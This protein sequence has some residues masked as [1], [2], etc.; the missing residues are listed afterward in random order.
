M[1]NRINWVAV[2][3]TVI[4]LEGLGFVWYA[5]L[6]GDVWTAA[7]TESFGRAPV[8]GD[9]AVMRSLGMVNTLILS[10]GLA[11]LLPKLGA[12]GLKAIKLA[13]MIW[14]A[15]GFT[16]MAIEYLYMGVG[17]KLVGLNMAYQLVAYLVAGAIIGWLPGRASAAPAE[18]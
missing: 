8:E 4:A 16:T 13:V 11:V 17:L 12:T 2:T 3:V 10:L 5:M 15:F 18:E 9:M 7:Y 1:F 14:F 6:F